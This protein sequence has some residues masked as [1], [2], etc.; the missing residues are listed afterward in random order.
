MTDRT[1]F[2]IPLDLS[3]RTAREERAK[4]RELLEFDRYCRDN[5]H[6]DQMAEGYAE[7][8]VVRVSWFNGTGKEYCAKLKEAGGGGAKHKVNDTVVWVN[9]DRALGE[10]TTAMLSPRQSIEGKEFDVVSYARI[11][12]R[13]RARDGGWE[14]LQGDCIYERDEIIPVVPGESLSIDLSTL[15]RFRASYKC[16]CYV[17]SLRGVVSD[18][19]LPGEDRPETVDALYADASTWIFD[20]NENPG[21]FT[22]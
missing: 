9:G 16:L 5:G 20:N 11:L 2:D 1:F 13:L 22:K 14:I 18:Q 15:E 10:M 3:D 4:I 21:D 12:T 8:S 6:F 19:E 17:Q 7:D